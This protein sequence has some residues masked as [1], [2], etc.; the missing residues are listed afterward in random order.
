MNRFWMWVL[1]LRYDW[2]HWQL[3]RLHLRRARIYQRMV[4]L[5]DEMRID[6]ARR[7]LLS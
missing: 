7:T 4:V 2:L 6:H 1:A 5:N 3:D